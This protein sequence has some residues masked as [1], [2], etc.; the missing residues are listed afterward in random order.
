MKVNLDYRYQVL[1]HGFQNSDISFNQVIIT[2]QNT[3]HYIF[4]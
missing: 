4:L 2:V 1:L 3:L